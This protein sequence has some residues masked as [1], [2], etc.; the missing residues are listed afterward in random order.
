MGTLTCCIAV[1]SIQRILTPQTLIPLGY[2]TSEPLTPILWFSPNWHDAVFAFPIISVAYLCHFNVLPLH[3]ELVQPTRPRIKV[4]IHWVMGLCSIIYSIIGVLG[5]SFARTQTD[6]NILNNFQIIDGI[7]N[8][9]RFALGLTLCL[10]FPL[11]VLPA[12]HQSFRLW[13]V[14]FIEPFATFDLKKQKINPQSNST[15]QN[16]I[17]PTT[18]TNLEF[19]LEGNQ[20]ND[21][22]VNSN[23]FMA[24]LQKK[25]K[26]MMKMIW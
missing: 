21:G 16:T 10:S 23:F 19:Q 5:Y 9:G 17:Y 25:K 3:S 14:F 11:L 2:D 22:K 18:N 1:R 8:V 24:H 15:T 4:M 26:M 13:N 12:R 20:R 7:M 6:G